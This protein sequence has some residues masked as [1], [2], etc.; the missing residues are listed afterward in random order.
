[1]GH[2]TDLTVRNLIRSHPGGILAKQPAETEGPLSYQPAV[3]QL[4]SFL[5]TMID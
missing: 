5:R 2:E 3:K 4:R 1:M